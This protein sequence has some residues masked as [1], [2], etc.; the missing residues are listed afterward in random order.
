MRQRCWSH[1][2]MY[3]LAVAPTLTQHCHIDLP[4]CQGIIAR[5]AWHLQAISIT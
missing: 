2:T 3:H 1:E 4:S 5:D